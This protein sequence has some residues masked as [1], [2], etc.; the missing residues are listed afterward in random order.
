MNNLTLIGFVGG[1]AEVIDMKKQDGSTVTTFSV[2]TKEVRGSG[3]A[4][5]E[6]VTWHKVTVYGGLQRFAST[7]EKGDLVSVSGPIHTQS[8][9]SRNGNVQTYAVRANNVQ[10]LK[11]K[12]A[13]TTEAPAEVAATIQASFDPDAPDAFPTNELI[14]N[15]HR[16]D[17][18]AED[19]L[20]A[21]IPYEGPSGQ[22]QTMSP[23]PKALELLAAQAEA[24]AAPK[25]KKTRTRKLA[26][27]P[28]AAAVAETEVTP[29]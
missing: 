19:R 27:K 12:T 13:R 7:I 25:A 11:R 16:H 23:T 8:F 26:A 1:N 15:S 24:K 22:F 2:A 14:N 9:A 18:E 29:A 3:E 10:M 5:K 17:E 20:D 6:Y 28:V 21:V 4:R